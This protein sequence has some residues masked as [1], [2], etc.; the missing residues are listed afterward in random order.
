MKRYPWLDAEA[1]E[2]PSWLE[3]AE[4]DKRLTNRWTNWLIATGLIGVLVA[5]LADHF[6]IGEFWDIVETELLR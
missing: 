1:I 4:K 2:S 5:I 6:E 3:P